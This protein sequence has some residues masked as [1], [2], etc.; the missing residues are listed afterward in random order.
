MIKI[1]IRNIIEGLEDLSSRDFQLTA[2]FENSK[3]LVSSFVEDVEAVFDDTGLEVALKQNKVVFDEVTDNALKELYEK[4]E[5]V[6]FSTPED[7]L[8]DSPEM[9]AVREKA[10]QAL[11][12]V[13][14]S[15]KS[16]STVE[17]IE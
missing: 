10:A 9:T 11:A 14:A 2:W 8:V 15:D 3:G 1:Y 6:G 12:L 4:I 13:K 16:V 17:I 5:L 7:K